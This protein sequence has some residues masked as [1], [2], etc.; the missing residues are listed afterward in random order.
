MF[1]VVLSLAVFFIFIFIPALLTYVVYR[2]VPMD[3]DKRRVL[4]GAALYPLALAGGSAYGYG[5]ERKHQPGN[6]SLS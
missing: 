4:K 3:E 1:W 2:S 5:Y 6:G